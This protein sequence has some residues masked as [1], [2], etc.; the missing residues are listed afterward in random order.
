MEAAERREEKRCWYDH[1]RIKVQELK[2]KEAK[3][4]SGLSCGPSNSSERL[5]RNIDKFAKAE[6]EF[7]IENVNVDKLVKQIHTLA[8]TILNELTIRFT[9]QVQLEFYEQMDRIFSKTKD[10]EA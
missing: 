8:N 9:V 4:K 6:T 1:Y 10:L 3:G 7:K 5:I 2:E